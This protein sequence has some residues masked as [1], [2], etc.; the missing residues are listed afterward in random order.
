MKMYA[1]RFTNIII[2]LAL[3]GNSYG[4]GKVV[5]RGHIQN[6]LSDSIVVSYSSPTTI[7]YETIEKSTLL[8]RGNFRLSFSVPDSYQSHYC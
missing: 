5:I 7:E 2:L 4:K 1:L 3:F 8:V 6:P